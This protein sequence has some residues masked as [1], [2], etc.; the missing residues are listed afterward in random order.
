[1]PQGIVASAVLLSK[2]QTERGAQR[3]E[4]LVPKSGLTSLAGIYF[5]DF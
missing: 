3:I 1:M 2:A 5:A 4:E